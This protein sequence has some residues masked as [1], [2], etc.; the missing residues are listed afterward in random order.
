MKKTVE[1]FAFSLW[2]IYLCNK[3]FHRIRFLRF[4]VSGSCET[5]ANFLSFC[6]DSVDGIWGR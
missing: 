4:K 6:T 5:V 1:I 2:H 3:F